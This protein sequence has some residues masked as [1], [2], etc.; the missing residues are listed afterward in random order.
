[1]TTTNIWFG[2]KPQEGTEYSSLV[3]ARAIHDMRAHPYQAGFVS[4]RWSY[5]GDKSADLIDW[6]SNLARPW[7]QAM[8]SIGDRSAEFRKDLVPYHA[9]IRING[10]YVYCGFWKDAQWK[11][12]SARDVRFFITQTQPNL[13]FSVKHE[14][15]IPKDGTLEDLTEIFVVKVEDPNYREYVM[16]ALAGSNAYLKSEKPLMS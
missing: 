2:L 3:G 14:L 11:F 12:S 5:A 16:N 9:H 1:M 13:K 8:V 10:G 4:D 15:V 7:I 6:I